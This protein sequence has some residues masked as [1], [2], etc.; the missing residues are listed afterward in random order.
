MQILVMR[1][2]YQNNLLD[3]GHPFFACCFVERYGPIFTPAANA[4]T[5]VPTALPMVED[6]IPP[7]G[8]G[9][10]NARGDFLALSVLDPNVPIPASFDNA[11]VYSG[12]AP[13]PD[14]QNTPAPSPN[15]ILPVV[16]GFGYHMAMSADLVVGTGGGDDIPVAVATGGQLVGSTAAIPVTCVLTTACEG[17][18]RLTNV[19]A[20]RQTAVSRAKTYGKA[21]FSIAS[22]ATAVVS[23]RLNAV[24]RRKTRRLSSVTLLASAKVG[25]GVATST[26]ALVRQQ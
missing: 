11:S 17:R 14:P 16:N 13:A 2:L 19:P 24:G 9:I 21:R 23:V 15:P 4:I 6:P 7:P 1:S 8:D 22:G 26:V 10:T 12:F 25:S 5:T 3:P 20:A 18:L